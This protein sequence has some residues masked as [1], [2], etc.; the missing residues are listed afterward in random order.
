M[1]IIRIA[2][3]AL[4]C[5]VALACASAPAQAQTS[6]KELV[7]KVLQLQQPGIEAMARSL[8]EQ[9]AIQIMQQAGQAVGTRVPADK[10]EAVGKEIQADARKYVDEAFPLVRDRAVKLAPGTIGVMLEEKFNEDELKQII[11]LLESPVNRKFQQMTVE[12]QQSLTAKLVGETRETVAPKISGLEQ[13]I[14]KRLAPYAPAKPASGAKA[15]P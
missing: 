2:S 14:A 10:R 1:T 7:A 3:A 11:A 4:S 12:M 9:P 6:K 8:I 15:K 5:A 13:A